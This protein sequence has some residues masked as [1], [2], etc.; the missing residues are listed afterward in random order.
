MHRGIDA[1][2]FTGSEKAGIAINKANAHRPGLILALE[3]GGNNP[4]VVWDVADLKAAALMVIQSAFVTS[5]QR[6]SC[7]RRLIVGPDGD[8]FL[9]Q[10]IEMT[11][12]VRVG[13]YTDRPEP[14]MG[15]VISD[16]AGAKLL[17][18]QG[19]LMAKGGEVLLEMK[20]VERQAM[21]TPGIIDVT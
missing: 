1:L 9:D 16:S 2:C 14:F 8:A 5:G 20:P 12:G 6:C 17:S 18:A 3:M 10:L 19:D 4:L 21:L 7:A 11:R 15:P 13:K